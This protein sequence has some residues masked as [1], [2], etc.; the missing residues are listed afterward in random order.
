MKKV[1]IFASL[2]QATPKLN[3]F[4]VENIIFLGEHALKPP[5]KHVAII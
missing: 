4:T 1:M 3:K 2:V 5:S